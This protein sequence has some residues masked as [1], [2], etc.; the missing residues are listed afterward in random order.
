M[1]SLVALLHFIEYRRAP[2]D[3]TK[4]HA[5]AFHLR[6]AFLPMKT[7]GQHLSHQIALK[8][9]V[10]TIFF[11]L[12]CLQI[13]VPQRKW[14]QNRYVSFDSKLPVR[15]IGMGFPK[16]INSFDWFTSL[17]KTESNKSMSHFRI[18]DGG[19][20]SELHDLGY[21]VHVSHL[22]LF[23]ANVV[24]TMQWELSY[25]AITYVKDLKIIRLLWLKSC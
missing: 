1:E 25:K 20:G 15:W 8:S 2:K 7:I 18:L 14:C 4:N 10:R 9:D 21:N 13:F 19:A 3:V 17:V 23:C 24:F 16:S 11:K 5:N 12:E 22:Y 6:W